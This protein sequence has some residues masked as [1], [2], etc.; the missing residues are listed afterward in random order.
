[1]AK[2]PIGVRWER[3]DG[4]GLLS[5]AQQRRYMNNG[6]TRSQ[7]RDRSNSLK[8]ARGHSETPEHPRDVVKHPERYVKYRKTIRAVVKAGNTT[9][10]VEIAG[11]SEPQRRVLARHWNAV[12]D[13]LDISRNIMSPF[14][15]RSLSSFKGKTYGGYELETREDQLAMLALRVDLPFE[16]IYPKVK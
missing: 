6:V 2:Q 7:Y 15:K 3:R 11:L 4:K 14:K 5:E 10:I 13:Y 9:E 16:D 1:M 12:W 8:A